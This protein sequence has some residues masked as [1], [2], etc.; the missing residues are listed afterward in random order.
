MHSGYHMCCVQEAGLDQL[1][2]LIQEDGYK[3]VRFNPYL[4]PDGESMNNELGRMM[5]QRCGPHYPH[6]P[7]V[8]VFSSRAGGGGEEAGAALHE[9][10]PCLAATHGRARVVGCTGA[11]SSG[12]WVLRCREAGP[13][14]IS[15]AA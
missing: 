15:G 9:R 4:W 11:W 2:K 6:C 5:Y 12:S 7:L 8:A 1:T 13:V 3:G 14:V 10:Q